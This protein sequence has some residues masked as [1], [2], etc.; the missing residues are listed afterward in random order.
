MLL[1]GA[2]LLFFASVVVA[3]EDFA[4]GKNPVVDGK[5]VCRV[6]AAAAQNYLA[7]TDKIM[8]APVPERPA[9]MAKVL[10]YVGVLEITSSVCLGVEIDPSRLDEEQQ[11]LL[12]E[13]KEPA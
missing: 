3:E 1:T 2:G 13:P 9:L 11:K 10:E 8:E 12:S 7:I 5:D 6:S 4:P